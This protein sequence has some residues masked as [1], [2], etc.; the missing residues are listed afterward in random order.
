M[1]STFHELDKIEKEFVST[2]NTS[3]TEEFNKIKKRANLMILYNLTSL[4]FEN[5][6]TLQE[7]KKIKNQCY[8]KCYQSYE[9]KNLDEIRSKRFL[10]CKN[11]CKGKYDKYKKKNLDIYFLLLRFYKNKTVKCGQFEKEEDFNDCIWM[12][13]NKVRRR[14][15][16]YWPK[17]LKKY[18]N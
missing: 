8:N 16:L 1:F 6:F 5:F 3:E 11:E 9:A 14:L 4:D 12:G 7:G 15:N 2:L 17:K 10:N 13:L 18:L